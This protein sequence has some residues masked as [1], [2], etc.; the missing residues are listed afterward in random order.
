MRQCTRRSGSA[1]LALG[2]ALLAPL[3]AL[4]GCTGTAPPWQPPAPPGGRPVLQG[5]PFRLVSFSSCDDLL[6]QLRGAARRAVGPYGLGFGGSKYAYPAAGAPGVAEDR[7]AAPAATPPPEHSTTNVQEAGVD[8][9]DLVKT[10]GRRIV[11]VHAGRL[12]VVDAATHRVTGTV[13]LDG[14]PRYND[15]GYS[16][17]AY[18]DAELLLAGDRALV[19]AHADYIPGLAPEGGTPAPGGSVLVLVQVDL[20]GAPRVTGRLTF[21]G[22]YVDARMV[23][24][25]ARVVLSSTPRLQFPYQRN[26]TDRQRTAA[27]QRVIDRAELDAWLPRYQLQRDGRT[28]GG[29]V[30]CDAVSTPAEFSGAALL[31]VLTLDLAGPLGSG[32]PVSVAADGDTVYASQTSLYVANDQRWRY[33]GGPIALDAPA[34][35]GPGG[36]DGRTEIYQFDI[37]GAGRP[38]F[39]A[40]GSVP[41]WLLN[42]Y[43]L[44]EFDGH[45]RLATT[46]AAPVPLGPAGNSPPGGTRNP[47]GGTQNS[48]WVLTR[49]DARLAVT[50]SVGGL[51]RGERVY[52]VRF[53][54]PVGYVVT[55]RQTD[56]LYVLDLRDPARPRVTGKLEL[57]G[58]SAYLHPLAG[59]RLLGV[60]Q[61]VDPQ[62]RR[63]EGMLVSLFDVA[64]PTRPA[65]TARYVLGGGY[66]EANYDP[67]AFLYWPATGT[68][69]LPVTGPTSGALVL[70]VHDGGLTE[71]GTLQPPTAQPYQPARRSLVVGGTL[72]TLFEGGLLASDLGTLARQGWVPLG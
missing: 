16:D 57:T 48:V 56:P 12:Q 9:P 3:L 38:A 5:A 31:T 13:Q 66:S 62:G 6:R 26:G 41:G 69:V 39:V 64:D 72:W 27:N 47:Q 34:R 10:D 59:N 11:T 55:F 28:S 46:T 67:H 33:W 15:P 36:P 61:E 20:A 23:G 65:R 42:Q 53:L 8:E 51:G 2:T 25:T 35:P 32:D 1:G 4:A 29:R 52:A 70:A 17:P 30:G 63:P 43:S 18:F 40:S 37:S 21:D 14:G 71:V 60:G 49:H 68:L 44:S 7:A 58:F 24:S 50:G 54:G 22:R 19:L 45:L